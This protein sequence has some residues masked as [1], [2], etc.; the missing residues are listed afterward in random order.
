MTAKHKS[1]LADHTGVLSENIAMRY[2][3]RFKC[4]LVNPT[5][6]QEIEREPLLAFSFYLSERVSILCHLAEEI[7]QDLDQGFACEESIDTYRVGRSDS[8]LWFWILGAYEVIRTMSQAKCCFSERVCKKLQALKVLLGAARMP[9][10]KMEKQG[11]KAYVSSKRSGSGWDIGNLDLFVNDPDEPLI[12]ARNLLDSFD[13]V[14]CSIAKDD[15][16]ARHE[17]CYEDK[18]KTE[19]LTLSI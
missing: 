14:V 9:A 11:K 16:L 2:L 1:M 15:V 12:S 7:V 4:V 19:R 13:A 18:T 10:A 5:E 17:T 3:Q 6:A 8:L